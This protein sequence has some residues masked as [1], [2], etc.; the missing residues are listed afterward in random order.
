MRYFA[1]IVAMLSLTACKTVHYQRSEVLQ[2]QNSIAILKDR[3]DLAISND[4][5]VLAPKQFAEAKVYLEEAVKEAQNSEDPRAGNKTAELGLR[6]LA[7]AE[8]VAKKAHNIFGEAFK[9]RRQAQ[10]AHAHLLFEKDFTDVDDELKD[11]ARKLELGN[12]R[13]GI[14][15]NV[16]LAGQ[17]A[18]LEKRALKKNL[19]EIAQRAYEQAVA[20]HARQHAPITL[21][22]AKSELEIAK[23]I[24]ELE[25][26]NFSKAQ[27]H[28][29]QARYL[30]LRAKYI[31]DLITGFKTERM[32]D[33]QFVL[34][35]QS[36]LE[37]IHSGMPYPIKFDLSNKDVVDKFSRDLNRTSSDLK[38]LE[39]KTVSKE[40]SFRE[41]SDLFSPEEAEVLRRGD[42]LIIRSFG[43]YFNVGKS[44][45]LP[46]NY[47]LLN[48][49]V[50]AIGKFP[51]SGIEVE[52]HTDSSGS[53]NINQRLSNE[54]AQNIADFLVKVAKI[55]AARVTSVGV[56]DERPIAVNDTDEGRKKNR[57]IE[58]I[59][60]NAR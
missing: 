45:L 9:K 25:K 40:A 56:G 5:E 12:D 11:A 4:V 34:W 30:A 15:K 27:F 53:P 57:R 32:T 43:F 33:E 6:S 37:Q 3:L 2:R 44:E 23:K 48:K 42:D 28:A 19:S 41:V 46:R 22:A 31:A 36:Q 24:I 59:I 52:G 16:T 50:T 49:I 60:K 38:N 7:Q 13:V 35:Y 14:E 39:A 8:D 18:D 47:D 54:R 1:L 51:K 58:V 29:E 10:E 20:A 26:E 17:Y 21:K 55:D